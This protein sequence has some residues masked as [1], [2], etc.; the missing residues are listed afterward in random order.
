MRDYH[1]TLNV[2][3]QAHNF[4]ELQI[5]IDT[6]R[7]AVLNKAVQPYKVEVEVLEVGEN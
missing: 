5:I 7:A 1:F 2:E 4:E 3:V 6:C